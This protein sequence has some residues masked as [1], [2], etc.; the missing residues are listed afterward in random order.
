MT[1]RP[2]HGIPA[3]PCPVCARAACLLV[4][5]KARPPAYADVVFCYHCASVLVL[6][7]D[8]T[9]RLLTP[10][11]IELALRAHPVL[12]TMTAAAAKCQMP[13]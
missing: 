1:K 11:E 10:I 7:A 6:Q 3:M 13:R 4:S 2:F 5:E 9:P 12:P 8:L